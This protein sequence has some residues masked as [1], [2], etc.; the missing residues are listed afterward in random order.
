MYIYGCLIKDIHGRFWMKF[1]LIKSWRF[2]WFSIVWRRLDCSWYRGFNFLLAWAI[3]GGILDWCRFDVWWFFCWVLPY[4][5]VWSWG[6]F[7]LFLFLHFC[8]DLKLAFS[9]YCLLKLLPTIVWILIRCRFDIRF[10]FR[11]YIDISHC[12]LCFT[13]HVLVDTDWVPTRVTHNGGW[14]TVTWTFWMHW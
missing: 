14:S 9:F 4:K 3:R 8:F 5:I 11:N 6:S 13:A 7:W 12:L 2:L 10:F 1:F